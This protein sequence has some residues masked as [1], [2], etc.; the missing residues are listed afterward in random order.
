MRKQG[1]RG[2]KR[3]VTEL[4]ENAGK[5][6]R[7]NFRELPNGTFMVGIRQVLS[8]NN[9]QTSSMQLLVSYT[10]VRHWEEMIDSIAQNC[11]PKKSYSLTAICIC[12]LT[13]E[14]LGEEDTGFYA[15]RQMMHDP[16]YG[17]ISYC[18]SLS[19]AFKLKLGYNVTLFLVEMKAS[20]RRNIAE[21]PIRLAKE[22]STSLVTVIY[23]PLQI[24]FLRLQRYPMKMKV[25]WLRRQ[26]R[27]SQTVVLM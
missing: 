16:L 15:P 7:G 11:G 23:A 3:P 8:G 14:E 12:N 26:V 6:A 22:I 4:G 25:W 10:D 9:D 21:H 5:K 13:Q 17:P 1:K 19:H 24:S 27:Q 2:D 18:S 20:A